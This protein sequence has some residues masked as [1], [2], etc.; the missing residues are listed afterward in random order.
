[1]LNPSTA[2]SLHDD[3]TIRRCI[4]YAWRWGFR[5]MHVVNLYAYR[6]TD[7]EELVK[8]TDPFGPDNIG[9]IA[10]AMDTSAMTVVAWGAHRMARSAL[11]A[12]TDQGRAYRDMFAP[13]KTYALAVNKDGSP[14]HPLYAKSDLDPSQWFMP[15]WNGPLL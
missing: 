15:G 13:L 8:A 4:G 1:M 6:A 14:K 11:V 7:P 12:M 9:H 5:G 2:D 3:P 10:K